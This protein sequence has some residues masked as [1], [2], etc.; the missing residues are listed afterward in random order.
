MSDVDKLRFSA[1]RLSLPPPAPYPPFCEA[2]TPRFPKNVEAAVRER[3]AGTRCRNRRNIQRTLARKSSRASVLVS[4]AALLERLLH[5]L[6][7]LSLRLVGHDEHPSVPPLPLAYP[8]VRDNDGE[9]IS[10]PIG[11]F[12]YPKKNRKGTS[13]ELQ[14]AHLIKSLSANKRFTRTE[15]AAVQLAQA[16]V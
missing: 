2:R 11:C 6:R 14:G 13:V 12:F 10:D 3:R 4:P 9:V 16:N 15:A 8:P 1:E 5:L 7:Q